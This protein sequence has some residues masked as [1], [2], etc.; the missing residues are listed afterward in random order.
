MKLH[1]QMLLFAKRPHYWRR[2]WQS[3][4]CP[5][6]S[7]VLYRCPLYPAT[8][9]VVDGEAISTGTREHTRHLTT[10]LLVYF[11]HQ[12]N[13]RLANCTDDSDRSR[14]YTCFALRLFICCL[15]KDIVECR[16]RSS[17]FFVIVIYCAW[18]IFAYPVFLHR[19]SKTRRYTLV[20][21]YSAH[22][23]FFV[24]IAPG[25]STL[26]YLLTYLT[27]YLRQILTDYLQ[28]SFEWRNERSAGVG[29]TSA[30][31][32]HTD[33]KHAQMNMQESSFVHRAEWKMKQTF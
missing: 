5:S 22:C 8:R 7:T 29:L 19:K 33:D 26:T 31:G 15:A 13:A 21:L 12:K 32:R 17:E 2:W 4:N 6:L 18:H 1:S 14:S 23:E 11:G 16:Y 27:P 20:L 25:I 3:Y 30:K 10:S 28:H 9:V 24:L